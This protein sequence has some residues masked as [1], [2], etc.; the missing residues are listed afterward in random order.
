MPDYFPVLEVT[1]N[2]VGIAAPVAEV[3][4]PAPAVT[5]NAIAWVDATATLTSSMAAVSG[6]LRAEVIGQASVS[7]MPLLQGKLSA[8]VE[9]ECSV[10]LDSFAVAVSGTITAGGRLR[11]YIAGDTMTLERLATQ[12]Y[13]L[14]GMEVESARDIDFARPRVLEIVNGALQLV[15]SRA[16][17]L[18]WFNREPAEL[19]FGSGETSKVLPDGVQ[20]LLGPVRIKDGT[21]L[22]ACGSLTEFRHAVELYFAGAAPASPRVYFLHKTGAVDGFDA[23]LLT[24]LIAPAPTAETTLE[25]EWTTEAPHYRETDLLNGTRVRVPHGYAETLLLPLVKQRAS[26]DGLFKNQQLR[27]A[28]AADY[29]RAMVQLGLVDPDS[30]AVQRNKPREAAVPA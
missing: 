26:L 27:L 10:V 2:V 30:T 13:N 15:Y 1:A 9:M 22:R 21:E 11:A 17:F 6:T 23:K 12:V 29:Q 14:W 20:T 8:R 18:D 28:I 7:L 25:V 3:V 24:L 19:V 5:I 16:A 4:P